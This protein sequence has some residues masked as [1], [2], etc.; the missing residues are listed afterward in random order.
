MN[1]HLVIPEVRP[2]GAYATMC[3][4]H[5][6]VGKSVRYGGLLLCVWFSNRFDKTKGIG[7]YRFPAFP[8]DIRQKG[9]RKSREIIGLNQN[10]RGYVVVAF[11]SKTTFLTPVQY[12]L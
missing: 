2:V 8:E 7:F 5:P 6:L 9:S 3:E 10:I 4:L 11:F 12:A 1:S